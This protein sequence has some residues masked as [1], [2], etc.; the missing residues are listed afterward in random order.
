MSQGGYQSLDR[1]HHSSPCIA[2]ATGGSGR[3]RAATAA[4]LVCLQRLPITG[5]GRSGVN[6]LRQHLCLLRPLTTVLAA[7]LLL[8]IYVLPYV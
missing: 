5:I 6:G 3:Y 2:A 1:R 7:L 4:T 8:Y